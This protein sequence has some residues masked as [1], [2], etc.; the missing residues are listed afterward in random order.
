MGDLGSNLYV[1]MPGGTGTG[2]DNA[3][4]IS[5]H[6]MKFYAT[7][8]HYTAKPAVNAVAG[9]T[10]GSAI[11]YA[12]SASTDSGI[13]NP[14]SLNN[15]SGG[16]GKAIAKNTPGNPVLLPK[17]EGSEEMGMLGGLKAP[18]GRKAAHLLGNSLRLDFSEESLINGIILSEILGKPKYLRKGRW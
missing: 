10:G 7:G 6:P 1:N 2:R 13:S 15:S 5:S 9:N 14:A 11:D 12:A 17:T 8:N 3:K 4:R 18:G 16:T